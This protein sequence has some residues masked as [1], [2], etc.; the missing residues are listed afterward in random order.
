MGDFG[1]GKSKLMRKLNGGDRLV[2]AKNGSSV[3]LLNFEDTQSTESRRNSLLPVLCN[4]ADLVCLCSRK[5]PTQMRELEQWEQNVH[6]AAPQL[7]P[8][9]CV[10][11]FPPAIVLDNY[12][13]ID[14]RYE[15]ALSKLREKY[16]VVFS[17]EKLLLQKLLSSYAQQHRPCI[18]LM[19]VEELRKFKVI[20]LNVDP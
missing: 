7:N 10:I 19:Q 15:I 8:A 16:D 9:F 12:D 1:V 4:N 20:D 18:A 14:A 2:L 5:D 11:L 3:V 6:D 17:D 13:V